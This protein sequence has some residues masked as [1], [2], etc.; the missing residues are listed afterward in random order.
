MGSAAAGVG[1]ADGVAG[2]D[3]DWVGGV[4]VT[5]GG[6]TV[7]GVDDRLDDTTGTGTLAKSEG[8]WLGRVEGDPPAGVEGVWLGV[9][10]G[11]TEGDTLAANGR[12]PCVAV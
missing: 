4:A 1:E 11:E 8:D 3:G 7:A 6:P 2:L 10:E 5:T 9:V 12:C